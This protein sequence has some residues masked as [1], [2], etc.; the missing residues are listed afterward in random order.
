[1]YIFIYVYMYVCVYIYIYFDKH[2]SQRVILRYLDN[3]IIKKA[4][5]N[6]VRDD[7]S[8]LAYKYVFHLLFTFLVGFA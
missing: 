3:Q 7:I 4:L 2:S 8:Y 1:M 5:F 6:N